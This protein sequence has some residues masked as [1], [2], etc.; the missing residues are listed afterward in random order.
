MPDQDTVV[1]NQEK[2][3][4]DKYFTLLLRRNR[5]RMW[6]TVLTIV[7]FVGIVGGVFYALMYDTAI[8]HAWKEILLLLLGAFIGAYGKVIDFWFTNSETDVELMRQANGG[9]NSPYSPRFEN[10]HSS[11]P[12]PPSQVVNVNCTGK[13]ETES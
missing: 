4:Q 9:I 12:C 8:A 13:E 7:L 3:E 10:I 1:E 11:S 6:I 5:S 2:N